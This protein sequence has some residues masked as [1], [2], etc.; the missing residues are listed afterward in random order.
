MKSYRNISEFIFE[1]I[2]SYIIP[3]NTILLLQINVSAI[4]GLCNF[5]VYQMAFKQGVELNLESTFSNR[6]F[7]CKTFRTMLFYS[8]KPYEALPVA[9]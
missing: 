1:C 2:R 5:L 6:I 9:I 8:S 7:H 3:E 4:F